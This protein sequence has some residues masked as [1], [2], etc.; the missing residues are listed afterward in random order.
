M[1][2]CP[3]VEGEIAHFEK[4][5]SGLEWFHFIY[6]GPEYWC[7]ILVFTFTFKFEI[8]NITLEKNSG[9]ILANW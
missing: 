5:I 2:V 4:K 3:K 6:F 1:Q 9:H 7:K 8:D